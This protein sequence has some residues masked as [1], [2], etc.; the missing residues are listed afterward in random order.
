MIVAD[1]NLIAYL[2]IRGNQTQKVQN[3][4]QLDPEWKLPYLWRHEFLNILNK[5]V[6][7]GGMPIEQSYIL[8]EKAIDTFLTSECPVDYQ[9]V[10]SVSVQYGISAY[11]AQYVSLAKQ[12]EI[13]LITEDKSLS[14]VCP[15]VI[16]T[17]NQYLMAAH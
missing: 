2:L 13:K 15:E 5:Y 4:Y 9:D 3:V 11:D 6:Q 7:H 14:R 8:W 12:L 16:L 10:L 17:S 1:V